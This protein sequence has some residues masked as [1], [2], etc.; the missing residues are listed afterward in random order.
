MG[1][2]GACGDGDDDDDNWAVMLFC[3]DSL[4]LGCSFSL[5][6]VVVVEAVVIVLVLIVSD[7]DFC[8]GIEE[9][10]WLL[11]G[12]SV[13][14]KLWAKSPLVVEKLEVLLE[15]AI[16]DIKSFPN[17]SPGIKL[18]VRFGGIGGISQFYR[19]QKRKKKKN[20]NFLNHK[21]NLKFRCHAENEVFGTQALRNYISGNKQSCK[22][23]KKE[24]VITTKKRYLVL[25]SAHWEFFTMIHNLLIS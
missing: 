21:Q 13:A 25:I 9:E 7:C 23:N 11:V 6:T 2:S 16:P 22:K 1:D 15:S 3:C 5:H 10:R 20:F 12:W 4:S 19:C 18:V 17:S 24:K 14:D 8:K